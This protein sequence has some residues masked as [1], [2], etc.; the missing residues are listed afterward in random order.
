MALKAHFTLHQDPTTLRQTHHYIF[1]EINILP[2]LSAFFY[3][4]LIHIKMSSEKDAMNKLAKL[5]DAKNFIQCCHRMYAH[6]R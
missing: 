4:L 1:L 2:L 3:F 6:L 5:T